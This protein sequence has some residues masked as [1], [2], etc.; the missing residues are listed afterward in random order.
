MDPISLSRISEC[1]LLKTLCLSGCGK[2][3]DDSLSII[4][5]GCPNIINIKLNGCYMITDTSLCD[6]IESHPLI[7]DILIGWITRFTTLFL[8]T[9][10]QVCS[11]LRTIAFIQCPQL[12]DEMLS[13]LGALSYLENFQLEGNNL[14]G[15]TDVGI[16]DVFTSSVELIKSVILKGVP[17]I[18]DKGKII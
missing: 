16:C 9:L 6:L 17:N 12:N 15:V 13:Y 4:S 5:R 18:T 3:T 1:S 2:L 10:S 8:K 11:K 7:E 14:E